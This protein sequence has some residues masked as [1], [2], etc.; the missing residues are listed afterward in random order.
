M[1]CVVNPIFSSETGN[2]LR[3][4]LG[5]WIFLGVVTLVVVLA[6]RAI[7]RVQKARLEPSR[8]RS[9]TA[10]DPEPVADVKKAG[11]SPSREKDEERQKLSRKQ[12]RKLQERDEAR[13][14]RGAEQVDLAVA[15]ESD[16]E[17][18]PVEAEADHG[19]LLPPGASLNEG[20]GRTRADG[21]VG[22]LSK[23][24]AGRVVDAALLD[25]IEAVLFTADIGVRTSEKLLEG[26]RQELTRKEHADAK[27]VW[28]CLREQATSILQPYDGVTPL[29]A[30]P[31]DRGEPYIV[32]V[33]G[34]NGA[35]KTTTIGKLAHRLAAG[36]CDVL[37]GAGDTFRAAATEQ[38]AVWA[39]RAGAQFVHGREGADPSSVL[40]DAVSQGQV[41]GVDVVLCDTAGRLHTNANL[42]EELRKIRRVIQKAQD[43]APHE[44]L[45]VV[46]ATNGQNAI[47]QARV[48]GE[49][50]EVTGVVLTKLDGTA[51][52]GVVLGISDELQ[53]PI[54]W[55]GVG[56]RTED[57]RPFQSQ[58]FV[59]ALFA[60]TDA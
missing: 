53:L 6:F 55:V 4:D 11:P 25:E 16:E 52:G 7:S 33:I 44:V 32:L 40:Y 54:R 45:L 38:L 51:K 41:K 27:R 58:E 42:V 49:A 37:V 23:L 24:F 35:G 15:E 19:L 47:Q 30:L 29:N 10:A 8:K 1:E 59:D 17:A 2:L 36:G 39:K 31:P 43:G 20:L 3:A 48:F 14:K 21:F 60:G 26:L 50:V 56:E 34:V 57:L 12:R 22:R 5:L 9:V 28:S 18:A 46:D 13:A